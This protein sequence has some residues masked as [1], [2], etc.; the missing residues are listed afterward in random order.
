MAHFA[1]INKYNLVTNVIVIDDINIINP[2]T[3][4]EDENIG[5]NLCKSSFGHDTTWVQTKLDGSIR[6]CY[7]GIGFYYDEEYDIFLPPKLYNSWHIDP[8]TLTWA[9]PVPRPNHDEDFK[10][11]YMWYEDKQIWFSIREYIYNKYAKD[12]EYSDIEEVVNQFNLADNRIVNVYENGPCKIGLEKVKNYILTHISYSKWSKKVAKQWIQEDTQ[13]NIK[14]N[15]ANVVRFGAKYCPTQEMK[16]TFKRFA[17]NYS[18][19][20]FVEEVNDFIIY[21]RDKAV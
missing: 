7:A 20:Y 10:F 11:S 19:Y 2:E 16:R 5:I 4:L 12:F 15:L 8:E 13:N 14:Y 3:G 6:K 17:E 18:D 9:P 1:K 21:R